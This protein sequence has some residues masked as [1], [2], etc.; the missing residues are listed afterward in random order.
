LSAQHDS[1]ERCPSSSYRSATGATAGLSAIFL[2]RDTPER[3]IALIQ[4]EAERW[5]PIIEA[6][7]LKA[8]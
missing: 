7:G 2:R 8:K 3:F 6:T 1:P 4:E 5:L